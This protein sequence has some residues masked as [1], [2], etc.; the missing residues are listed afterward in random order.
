[1]KNLL[2]ALLFVL[3]TA[4]FS[5]GPSCVAGMEV[6]IVDA[7]GKVIQTGKLNNQGKLTLNKVI[8]RGWDVKLTNNGKSIVLGVYKK[9]EEIDK[10]TPI[11]YKGK[12]SDFKDGS[13]LLASHE[14]AHVVQQKNGSSGEAGI[15]ETNSAE[16]ADA[17]INT[18]RSNIKQQNRSFGDGHETN[19]NSSDATISVTDN[20]KGKV[21]IQ[22]IC[23]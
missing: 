19:Q 3:P 16:R 20:G 15:D 5:A 1:M 6:S 8:V 14:A 22:V 7:S 18:S 11:L 17:N 9:T 12:I 2:L 23:K 21:D 13:A 4:L 10:A